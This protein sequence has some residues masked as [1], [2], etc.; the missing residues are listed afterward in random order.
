MTS[1]VG[2]RRRWTALGALAALLLVVPSAGANIATAPLLTWQTN[3]RVLAILQV[4]STTYVGGKFTQISN[5]AG[6]MT[7]AVSNLAAFTTSGTPVAATMPTPN[8]AVKA[9]ATDGSGNVLFAGS[10]TKVGTRGRNHIAEMTAGGTLIAKSAWAGAA[11]GDVEALAVSGSNLYMAGT[12]TAADGQARTELAAVALTDGSLQPWAPFVDGRVDDL[13]VNGGNIVAG[14]FFPNA[15]SAGS[16]HR[17]VAAFDATSGALQPNYV[18][19]GNSPIVSMAEDGSGGI[20]VGTESNRMIGFNSGGSPIWQQQFD[21]NV[22]AIAMSDGKVVAGGHFDNLCTLGTNCA[23]PVVRLHIAAL[24][25]SDGSLDTTWAPSI[26][27]TLGVFALA[28]TTI[29]LGLGG[30][31]TKVGGVS[32]THLA[33]LATG[34]SVPID[35][36]APTIPVTPDA[37]LRKAT[38]VTGGAV[39]LLVRFTATDP[40]GICATHLQRSTNGAA[41]VTVSLPTTTAASK[42]VTLVPSA[43]TYRYQASAAD[44]VGNASAFFKV[45]SVRLTAFQDRNAGI[46][47]TAA[48]A[49]AGAPKAYGGTIHSTSKAGA[50]ARFRFTGRQV[51]WVASRTATRGSGRVY[52]DGRLTATVDLHNATAV[53]RRIVFAHAWSGDGVHTI[54]IVSAGTPGHPTID[55]D[56]FVTVR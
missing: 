51:A 4:G 21:G 30:D 37:I 9:F 45:P 35:S 31:F 23:N 36:A 15:G 1:S 19:P 22:Q 17:Y 28:D 34:S 56:A 43:K 16:G 26:D 44:C 25:P 6:T 54:K 46:A 29:G 49:R 27:S 53:H 41:F 3:G 47:Y 55:V 39:P 38:T 5:R 11:N 7:Q 24:D 14:G 50:Y 40:S 10:F 33:F 12:F 8:G 42:P 48:W 32:Q 2:A 52:L 18:T 20:Y 13:A